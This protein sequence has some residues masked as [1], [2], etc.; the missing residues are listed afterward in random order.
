MILGF[1]WLDKH[2]PE[3]D[4]CTQSVKMTRCLLCCCIGCQTERKA[5]QNAKKEDAALINTCRMGPFPA[6]VEDA[7]KEED[8]LEEKPKCLF[9]AE[10]NDSDEPLEEGD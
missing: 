5:E 1:T 10:P 3:I 2:N 8:E 4:F 9:D 6:F 7:D